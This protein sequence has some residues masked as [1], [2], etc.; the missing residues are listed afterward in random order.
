MK[1]IEWNPSRAGHEEPCLNQRG[2][3]RKAKYWLMT[4]S[5]RVQWWKGEK[6][7]E[8]LS[9]IEPETISL[10]TVGALWIV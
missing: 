4:D 9:E 2:P 1:L 5:E 8:K 3:S 6:N 7:S 10:Q